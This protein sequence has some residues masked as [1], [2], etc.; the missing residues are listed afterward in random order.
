MD[1]YNEIVDIIRNKV[2]DIRHVDVETLDENSNLKYDY[3][4]KST[5][6]VVVISAL[7]DEY[8]AYI[9]LMK[10]NKFD[11]IGE[12]AKFVQELLEG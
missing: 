10:L 6:M 2:A 11:T 12:I 8:D 5:E 3:Q 9:D 1:L 7:E 4:I